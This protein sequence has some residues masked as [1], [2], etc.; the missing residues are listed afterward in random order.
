[1][2]TLYRGKIQILI[3][4]T[5]VHGRRGTTTKTDQHGWATEHNQLGADRDIAFLDVLLANVTQAT[6]NHDR[7]MITTHLFSSRTG[8]HFFK[9][10]EI[11]SQVRP[12]KLVVKSRAANRPLNHDVE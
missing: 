11:S 2:V 5:G 8:H 7:L 10:T 12:T 1:V 9:G 4:G 6:G 3:A